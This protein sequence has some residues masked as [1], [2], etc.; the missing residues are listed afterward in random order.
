MLL[1]A[2]IFVCVLSTSSSTENLPLII[3][4][5]TFIN[6]TAAGKWC[7]LVNARGCDVW[8]VTSPYN[9]HLSDMLDK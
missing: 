5:W 3:N 1:Q 6:A 7:L 4:T 8:F 9:M 2:I